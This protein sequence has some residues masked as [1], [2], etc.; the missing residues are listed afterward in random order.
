MQKQLVDD[1]TEELFNNFLNTDNLLEPKFDNLLKTINYL[2]IRPDDKE[3][4]IKFKDIIINKF[5]LQ[6]HNA[7]IRMLTSD[8][9][10]DD[11]FA[12]IQLRSMDAKLLSNNNL[13]VKVV[14]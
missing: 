7:I 10:I 14:R 9:H 1:V 6:E 11:R 13:K 12:N 3:S 8:D 4:I 5:K 2:D